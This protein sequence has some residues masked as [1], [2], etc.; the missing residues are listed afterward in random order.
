MQFVVTIDGFVYSALSY[1]KVYN[2]ITKQIILTQW[3]SGRALAL[4]V[5]GHRDDPTWNVP[6][7]STMI[8]TASFLITRYEK[9]CVWELFDSNG[10]GDGRWLKPIG[11]GRSPDFD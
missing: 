4:C 11:P 7:T 10:N 1:L 2:L 9:K 5:G 8:H 3:S 6:K